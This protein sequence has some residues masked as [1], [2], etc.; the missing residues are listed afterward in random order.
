[1]SKILWKPRKPEKTKISEMIDDINKSYG[2]DIHSYEELHKWSIE[3][4]SAFWNEIWSKCRIIHSVG[5][6]EVIDDENKMPGA[7]WFKNSRLNF[8][9]NL[10]RFRDNK[11]AIQF[12]GEKSPLRTISYREIYDEVEKLAHSLRLSG[13]KKGDRVAGLLPNIPE[14]ISAMLATSSIGAIWSSC[15]PDF[16][17]KGVLDRFTQIKPRIIFITNGYYYNGNYFNTLKNMSNILKKLPSVE[18]VIIINYPK[19][20]NSTTIN[21]SITYKEFLSKN[22]APLKFEQLPFD[23]PLYIMYSSGTTGLPKSIVHS[24][25]GTLIQHLKELSL[26]CDLKRDDCIFYFTT[27]GWMMWNW[28]ISSLSLGATIVLFDGSPF[29]PNGENLWK[30]AEEMNITVFGTSAT[31]IN[32]CKDSNIIP[33]NFVNLSK[34]RMILSTGSPLSDENFDYVYE[35]VKKNVLLGSISGGTDIISCFA[36]SNP[37][38]P[39][40]RGEL[41]CK[42]LGMNIHAFNLLGE[43]IIGEKGELVCSSP[44]PSMPIYFWNDENGLKYE[45]TYFTKYPN[46]WHHGDYIRISNEGTIKI[47]GRS[48][49]TLNPGGVRIGT[50]EIYRIVESIDVIEDSIAIGQD[51]NENQRIILFVIMKDN[52]ALNQKMI[53]EIKTKIRKNCT[54]RHVPKK[55]IKIAGI[56]YTLNGKK[57]EVAVK[58]IIEGKEVL[59]I[60]SL[61]NP[62]TLK[63]YKNIIELKI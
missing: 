49:A 43:S 60:E 19:I 15:S 16:G 31:Y 54:P 30:L 44:F 37:I 17:T 8:A 62:E 50:S 25:G 1:M 57:V 29:Y 63:Y 4:I 28:M 27:C 22:P 45:S 33:K 12:K 20:D 59:N 35:K 56:P 18:K 13:I 40:H 58:R 42:G 61:S 36:I 39:V 38:L 6:T 52:I 24:S 41:Q 48:D 23:H 21:K 53:D 51:Y 55:I 47:Y 10:L 9:E 7:K 32:A 34:L 5:F 3:N 26:H 14:T 46:I 11:I 2:K